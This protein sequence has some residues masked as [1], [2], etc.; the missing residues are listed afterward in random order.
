VDQ[1]KDVVIVTGSSGLIGSAVTKRF[2]ERFE[3]IGFD[4]EGPQ[5]SSQ[6]SEYVYVD[7][8]SDESVQHGLSDVRE[9]WVKPDKRRKSLIGFPILRLTST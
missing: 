2:T 5:D 9:H 3:T 1:K 7:V 8:T 4:R 6:V